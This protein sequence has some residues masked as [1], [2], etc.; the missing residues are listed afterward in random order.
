MLV[1]DSQCLT[2]LFTDSDLARLLEQKK[3]S[4]FDTSISHFMTEQPICIQDKKMLSEAVEIL[5][6]RRISELPVVNSQHQP[7]GMID[8]TDTV[9]LLPANESDR[10]STI[11]FPQQHED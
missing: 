1:D 5:A 4:C 11:P 6:E 2:G 7:V 9:A 3:E 8:I 10:K